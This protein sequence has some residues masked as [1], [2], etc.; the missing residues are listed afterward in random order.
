MGEDAAG[1]GPEVSRGFDIEGADV[2]AGRVADVKVG[3][4]GREGQSVGLLEIVGEQA[5]LGRHRSLQVQAVDAL[6]MELAIAPGPR[7]KGDR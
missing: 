2:V 3:L 6:E 5:N 7:R 1:A 4:V